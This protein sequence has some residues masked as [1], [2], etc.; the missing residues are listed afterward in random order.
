MNFQKFI[1]FGVLISI[2]VITMASWT[3][4][5]E[6]SFVTQS[7]TNNESEDEFSIH[8]ARGHIEDIVFVKEV[9]PAGVIEIDEI[10]FTVVNDDQNVHSF[11]ICAIIKG[12]SGTYSPPI[13]NAPACTNTELIEGSSK[14]VNQPIDFLNAINVSDIV[15]ISISIEEK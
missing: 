14:S 1:I 13:G 7:F 12:P 15:D 2:L 4:A 8:T 5:E 6:S 9:S 3:M 10:T 11:Q